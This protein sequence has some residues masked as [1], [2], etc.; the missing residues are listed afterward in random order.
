MSEK[1][2]SSNK[3]TKIPEGI[4]QLPK[5]TVHCFPARKS[6]IVS[7]RIVTSIIAALMVVADLYLVIGDTNPSP[8]IWAVTGVIFV[9]CV[10]IFIQTFL[11]AKYRVAMD[12]NRNCVILRYMY[13]TVSI[14]FDSFDARDGEADR[15]TAMLQGSTIGANMERNSYLILDNVF[16]DVCYQTS[17]K[18]LESKEDYNQLCEEAKLVSSIYKAKEQYDALKAEVVEQETLG[19]DASVDLVHEVMKED[20]AEKAE[21]KEKAIKAAANQENSSET[22]VEETPKS[23]DE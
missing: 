1:T 17:R 15:A 23:I 9:S 16:D 18:D 5:N 22:N 11:I 21:E 3:V 10:V 6:Q 7:R 4:D 12:Y 2:E 14:P 20:K 13:S 19:K 8:L